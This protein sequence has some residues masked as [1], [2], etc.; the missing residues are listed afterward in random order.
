MRRLMWQLLV[1]AN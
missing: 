1:V